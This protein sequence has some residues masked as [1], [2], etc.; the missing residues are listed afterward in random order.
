[1]ELDEYVKL[2]ESAERADEFMDE[3][4]RKHFIKKALSAS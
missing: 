3:H 1:M 4:Y 2:H